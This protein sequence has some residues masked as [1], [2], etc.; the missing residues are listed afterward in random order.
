MALGNR[1]P[2]LRLATLIRRTGEQGVAPLGLSWE[3]FEMIAAL[4]RQGPPFAMN[5][6]LILRE[7]RS[8]MG[9]SGTMGWGG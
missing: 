5:P 8:G 3:T 1:R 7:V 4:R 2:H 6:T 9:P